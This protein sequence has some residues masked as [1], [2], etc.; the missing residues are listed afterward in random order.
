[1]LFLSSSVQSYQCSQSK[2]QKVLPQEENKVVTE[3]NFRQ[4]KDY[5]AAGYLS[6]LS[7]PIVSSISEEAVMTS[8]VVTTGIV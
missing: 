1:M 3:E 2:L 7:N 8:R 4:V 6:L 5:F